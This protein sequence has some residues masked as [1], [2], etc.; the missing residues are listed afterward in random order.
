MRNIC[1]THK[2]PSEEFLGNFGSYKI[3]S[4]NRN[5]GRHHVLNASLNIIGDGE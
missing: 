5:T 1:N 2:L 4:G 3:G